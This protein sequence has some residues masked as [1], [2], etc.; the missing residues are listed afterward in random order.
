MD[1]P[2]SY[3]F[4]LSLITVVGVGMW[5]GNDLLSFT[6]FYIEYLFS[7]DIRSLQST[8]IVQYDSPRGP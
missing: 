1:G 4:D 7:K 8:S 6:K 5:S 3:G 2:C